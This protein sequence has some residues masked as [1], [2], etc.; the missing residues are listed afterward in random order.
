[1][2]IWVKISLIH[3]RELHIM[4]IS[5]SISS[6]YVLLFVRERHDTKIR[7]KWRDKILR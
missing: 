5:A 7:S 6:S 1:M 2:N 3:I 4:D